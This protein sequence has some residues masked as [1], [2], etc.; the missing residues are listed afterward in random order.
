M[1]SDKRA[2]RED[3]SDLSIDLANF[4]LGQ[5]TLEQIM[6]CIDAYVNRKVLE[7]QIDELD[8]WFAEY[9]D[10]DQWLN[11]KPISTQAIARRRL[12]LQAQRAA[13]TQKEEL[14]EQ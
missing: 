4:Y 3:G 9:F 11:T 2:E 8:H 10:N 12:E 1:T 6:T 7:A 13:L 14:D 5:L